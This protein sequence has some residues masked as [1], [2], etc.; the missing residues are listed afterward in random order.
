MSNMT[1]IKP[2]ALEVGMTILRWDRNNHPWP[3]RVLGVNRTRDDL[4]RTIYR[5]RIERPSEADPLYFPDRF[6]LFPQSRVRLAQEAS[7][8]V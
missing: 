1:Q 8:G 6:I 3:C 5:V 4:D 7:N 2:N